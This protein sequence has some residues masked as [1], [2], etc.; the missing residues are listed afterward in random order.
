VALTLNEEVIMTN[1]IKSAGGGVQV[2]TPCLTCAVE[3]VCGIVVVMKHSAQQITACEH[4][5]LTTRRITTKDV[6]DCK[7]VT[8][9][10]KRTPICMDGSFHT[11]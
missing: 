2:W 6:S 10:Y 8:H 1:N 11:P 3:A 9:S 5:T 4:R 7:L